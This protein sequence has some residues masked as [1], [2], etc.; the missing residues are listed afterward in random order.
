MTRCLGIAVLLTACAAHAQQLSIRRYDVPDGLAHSCV[1]AIHQDRQGYLWIATWEWLSRF[2]GYHFT[3]Y[4]KRDGLGEFSVI[5]DVTEDRRGRL[6]VA[7]NGSGVARLIDDPSEVAAT[8]PAGRRK[9]AL[10]KVGDSPFANQVN[11]IVFDA[12]DNLWC[13]TDA[14]IYR[15]AMN[16]AGD[17]DF[18]LV[19]PGAQP[20]F[21]QGALADSRGRL[22]FSQR[23]P[24][25]PTLVE[26]IEI[27]GGEMIKYDPARRSRNREIV[28]LIE[29]RQGRI[30][31]ADTSGLY[32]FVEPRGNERRGQWR[33]APLRLKPNQHLTTLLADINGVIWIGTTRGLIKY[34]DGRQTLYTSAQGLSDEFITA[35][36][37]DR[38]GNLWIGTASGG[39]CKLAGEMIVSFTRAEGL[40]DQNVGWLI[41]DRQGRIYA[42]TFGTGVVEIAG[43]R[44]I[45]V[46]GSQSPPFN[47]IWGRLLQDR[48]GDWW[49]GTGEGLFRFSGPMLQLR[50]GQKF[51]PADGVP[52][53]TVSD[54]LYEDA[55]G[56]IWAGWYEKGTY[57]SLPE[58]GRRP[59]FRQAS[60]ESHPGV[61]T[62]DQS[63]ALWMATPGW[64]GKL[65][66]GRV[67]AMQ[68]SAG[69]PE[70]RPRVIF[71]D[72]RGWLWVGLRYKGASVTKNPSAEQPEFVNY[73]TAQGLASDNVRGIAEDGFGRIYLGT[74]KGL[75][76]FDPATGSIRHFTT[77]DGLAGD[78]I[79][80]CLRDRHGNIWIAASGGVSRFDP[81]AERPLSQSYPAYLTR[82]TVAGDD[83]PLRE[84][85]QQSVAEEI[86]PAN[87]NNLLIEYAG[88]SFA[89]ERALRYQYKL[90]GVDEDWSQPGAQR[91]VNYARLAP[92]A[93][94]FLVRAVNREGAPSPAP[95]E[96]SI[97]ILPP[98]WQRWW[99]LSGATLALGAIAY[100][101]YRM[102]IRQFLAMERIRRQIATDLHD[103]VGSGLAQIAIL[104]EV[105]KRETSPAGVTH[106][107]EVANMARALREA[108]SDIVWAV[109]PRHDQPA[110]LVHRMKQTIANFIETDGPQIEFHAP[111][112]AALARISLAPDHRRHLLL[113]FKEALTNAVRHG[114]A[115]YIWIKVEV[116]A[117]ELGMTIGDD[118]RGFDARA[119]YD[120][121]GLPSLHQRA[122]ALRARL[123]I[124]SRPEPG[125]V[126]RVTLPLK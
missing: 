108:M 88:L 41:E 55:E 81:R 107:T 45:L 6:W 76:Q 104:S 67:I 95:A 66:G 16:R 90:E 33:R 59:R 69:L 25:S 34:R 36:S 31:A 62:A 8:K 22:W 70:L 15:A 35:L 24:S 50:R 94:R 60:V 114:H 111:E 96:F 57:W 26:V 53:G 38:E 48:R 18:K 105:A 98:L 3:N 72:S 68:P 120:G 71:L 124:M 116:T 1:T 106:L 5:N 63:G 23:T 97:R 87:R 121:H 2:D 40:P 11:R 65:T 101:F 103:D 119:N 9:F 44:A 4:D 54:R 17:C 39:L 74:G 49:V 99:F 78:S 29:D 52:E 92:G 64:L 7:T 51:T 82:I 84:R 85:G 56:R 73:S 93:Y 19:A 83:L 30:L 102:R 89:G 28:S 13:L 79:T 14:G 118:G 10:Y 110:D 80:Y 113:I 125:T 43:D 21:S 100:A 46:P 126:V 86:M 112:D 42:S 37:Q 123:D 58:P 77:A 12:D 61:M 47:A 91:A 75:N 27:A 109:D 122:A 115:S 32:E 117:N 20:I